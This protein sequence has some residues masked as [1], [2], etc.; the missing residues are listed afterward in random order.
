MHN[1]VEWLST[2]Q[3]IQN[4]FAFSDAHQEQQVAPHVRRVNRN[5]TMPLPYFYSVY[6]KVCTPFIWNR[7]FYNQM[8][9]GLDSE[10]C[11]E[12]IYIYITLNQHN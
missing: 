10:R 7:S 3:T 8:N 6:A 4:Q 2:Q 1:T 11:S 9:G 5:C 12:K